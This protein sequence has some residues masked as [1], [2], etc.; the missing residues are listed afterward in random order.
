MRSPH[1]GRAT[2]DFFRKFLTMAVVYGVMAHSYTNLLYHILFS[3]KN[4]KRSI[5]PEI[6]NRL[7]QYIGGTIRALGGVA[8]EV[9][10]VDDH[11]HAAAKVPPTISI[12]DF[13]GK[14][15]ANTSK[16]AK[17]HCKGFAW[18]EGYTAFTVS[19]SQLQHLREYIRNQEK[20]HCKMTFQE[21]LAKLLT[22]HRIKFDAQ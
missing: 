9:N 3:T 15:K 10:G 16:W 17:R 1:I 4:R 18:Q 2:E 5:R 6:R 8:L 19:E 14:L 21:E 20:H 11:V 13:L 12:S 7:H 22:A